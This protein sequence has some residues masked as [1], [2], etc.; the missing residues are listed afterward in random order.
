MTFEEC[1][2]KLNKIVT[3]LDTG[4]LSLEDSLEKYKEGIT[5][6]KECKKRL[7]EAKLQIEIID[8]K[9]D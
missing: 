9:E 3:E 4:E 6:T 2:E 7:D 8:E 1:L 5:L